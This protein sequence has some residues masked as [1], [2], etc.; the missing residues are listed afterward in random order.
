MARQVHFSRRARLFAAFAALLCIETKMVPLAFSQDD[1]PMA[2]L[3]Q[4]W[5]KNQQ[6]LWY[7]ATQG[8]RLIPFDWLRALEQPGNPALFM[9]PEHIAQFGYLPR[10]TAG[11]EQL[12]VGFVID[13]G[14]DKDLQRTKLRWKPG[15]TETEAWVG[16]TCSACHTSELSYK[17]RKIRVDGGPALA[18]FQSFIEQL[19]KALKQTVSDSDKWDRFAQ[20]VLQDK[21]KSDSRKNLKSA[22]QQL[23]EWQEREEN[24]NK[25]ELRYGFGRVD[26]FGHIY[27]K[28]ALLVGASNPRRNPS[29]APVSIPFIWSAPQLDRVQYN[30]MASKYV[31]AGIDVGGLGR[32]TGE[33][34][35]VFGD[36]KT[37]VN[38]G[39]SGFD[40]SVNVGNLVAL[41]KQLGMLLPPKWP[42][43]VFGA[44]DAD[45]ANAGRDLYKAHCESCHAVR[46]RTNIEN[47]IKIEMALFDG[48]GR[49][50]ATGQKIPPPGTDPWMACNA[51]DRKT[52]SGVLEGFP[53][54]YFTGDPLSKTHAI[55][56]LLKVSVAGTLVGKKWAL[57]KEAAAEFFR[58]PRPPIVD[59][60]APFPPDGHPH[61][62]PEKAAQLQTCFSRASLFLG[63]TSRPLNGIWATAPYLHNGSVPTLYELLSP[64]EERST[65]FYVGT[66]EYDPK[67]VGFVR[68][69]EEVVDGK[70]LNPGNS[71]L[72]QTRYPDGSVID[73][74]S[75]DGHNYGRIE[76]GDRRKIIEYLKT[77]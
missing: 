21:N 39:L 19:N 66:R 46:D 11:G 1:P 49:S 69:K 70:I 32:N 44:V 22:L 53:S 55:S 36:V 42:A 57:S 7:E 31:V 12:A 25:T 73:G 9:Q 33:V 52:V 61:R 54:S 65:E 28:V 45:L 47:P 62:S 74:N 59:A 63:Y 38:P 60:A 58:I 72:Y 8:S 30:G 75:N 6:V 18:D 27:N 51:Y 3:D 64:P 4:R 14:S 16:M 68:K 67:D 41:E 26:A 24:M 23:A 50:N 37:K 35:G 15:Q 13:R 5:G 56:D 29:D 2:E 76:P 40:S 34:I 17:G 77:L 48:S 20:R 43:S 71:F 10:K